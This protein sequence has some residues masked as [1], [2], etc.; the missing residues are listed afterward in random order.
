MTGLE[1]AF[2]AFALAWT[3]TFVSVVA[4]AALSRAAVR[5]LRVWT[6][7]VAVQALACVGWGALVYGS[8]A[9]VPTLVAG[10]VATALAGAAAR[11]ASGRIPGKMA[12]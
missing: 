8:R 10:V 1:G 3:G 9:I 11:M 5:T 7:A 4:Y 2:V 12:P 6:G